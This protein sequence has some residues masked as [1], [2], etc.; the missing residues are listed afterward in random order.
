MNI[1][2]NV[3]RIK[4]CFNNNNNNN[5]NNKNNNNNNNNYVDGQICYHLYF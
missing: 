4:W 5:N 1:V 3:K 2:I